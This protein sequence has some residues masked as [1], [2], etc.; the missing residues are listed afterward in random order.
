MT[1]DPRLLAAMKSKLRLSRAAIYKRIAKH[2]SRLGE[3]PDIAALEVASLEGINFQRFATK[4]QLDRLRAARSAVSSVAVSAPAQS[5]RTASKGGRAKIRT[6][7]PGK[8]VWMFTA[9]TIGCAVPCSTSYAVSDFSRWNGH[10][11]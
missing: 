4:D 2:A 11:L 7:S 1:V 5:T 9:G 6:R 10:L 3:R 8:H